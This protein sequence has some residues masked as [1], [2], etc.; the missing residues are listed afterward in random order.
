[1]LRTPTRLRSLL[2]AAF[3]LSAASACGDGTGT[4]MGKVS[5]LLTDAPGDVKKAVVTIS[6]IYLVG[7]A[8]GAE[9]DAAGHVVLRSE[10]VTTD[11]LTLAGTTSDLVKDAV[12]P[13]GTYGQLRFVVTGAYIEVEDDLGGTKIYASSPTYEG[14]PEGA[15]V[16]G[17]L[18]MPSYST[19]GFKVTLPGDALRVSDGETSMLVDFDVSQSFGHPVGDITKWVLSPVLIGE[20]VESEPAARMAR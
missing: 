4:R 13:A 6:R 15:Q 5:I 1:M 18:Q 12:I 16:D 17:T 14:L 3:V 10:P 11:L 7:G 2:S 20:K 19:S 9:S 8:A